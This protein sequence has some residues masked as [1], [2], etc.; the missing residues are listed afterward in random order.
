MKN[1]SLDFQT[2]GFLVATRAA[3]G[4]G[5]G[6]LLAD[7]LPA[8]RRRAIGMTLVGLGAATT[9]PAVA[10]VL[11]GRRPSPALPPGV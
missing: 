3:L 1:L 9:V 5:I 11:R 6:L 4:V 8:A 10:A 2:L 7:R